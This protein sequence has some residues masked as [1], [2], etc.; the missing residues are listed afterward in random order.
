LVNVGQYLLIP[1]GTD[2][3]GYPR[4]F[5]NIGWEK[6]TGLNHINYYLLVIT[7]YI[8]GWSGAQCKNTNGEPKPEWENGTTPSVH[9]RMSEIYLNSKISL[10]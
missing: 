8:I 3:T 9:K 7:S 5:G 2:K 1:V 10:H 6:K 4:D